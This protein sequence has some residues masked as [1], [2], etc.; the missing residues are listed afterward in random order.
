VRGQLAPNHPPI[1]DRAVWVLAV[2]ILALI[3]AQAMGLFGHDVLIPKV[4]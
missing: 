2:V 1:I 3:L 4:R